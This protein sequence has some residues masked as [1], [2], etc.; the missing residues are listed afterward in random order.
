MRY[1]P[2]NNDL[3]GFRFCSFMLLRTFTNVSSVDNPKIS[4]NACLICSNS[5]KKD[6]PGTAHSNKKFVRDSKPLVT[7]IDQNESEYMINLSKC[8]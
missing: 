1:Y 3:T 4:R 7:Y 5:S 2:L 6:K 8:N